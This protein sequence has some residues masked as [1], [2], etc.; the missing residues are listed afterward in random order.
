MHTINTNWSGPHLE[1][2]SPVSYSP[3]TDCLPDLIQWGLPEA[4]RPMKCQLTSKDYMLLER[5][6]TRPSPARTIS[7]LALALIRT[8]LAES[9]LVMPDDVAPEVATGNSRIVFSLDGRPDETRVL[10][11]SEGHATTGL[12]LSVTTLLGATLL[13]L[14]SGQQVPLLRADGSLG[15]VLLREVAYQPEAQRDNA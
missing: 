11:H 1:A 12:S 6:L 15:Q 9:Q 3:I 5:H 8:K 2:G 14:H 13:G 7:P 4:L 10:I